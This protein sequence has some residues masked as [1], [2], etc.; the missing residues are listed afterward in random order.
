MDLRGLDDRA[1][2]L[3]AMIRRIK[4]VISV[5]VMFSG[6]GLIEEIHVLASGGRNA[7][8]LVR[9][10]ESALMAQGI[11]IDHKKISIAQL[12]PEEPAAAASERIR[13]LGY[14]VGL[15][16]RTAEVKVRLDWHGASCEGSA[17]GPATANG[18]L[19]VVAEATLRALQQRVPMPATMYLE[20]CTVVKVG[21]HQVVAV[22]IIEVAEN[23][24]LGLVGSCLLGQDDIE[25]VIKATLDALNRRMS[26]LLGTTTS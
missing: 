14:T 9:D 17:Q 26:M 4:D 24:E 19:R 7:K 1:R 12:T 6:D 21:G 23:K 2:E 22:S 15:N 16:G 8:Q 13:I 11:T 25:S 18:R 5:R 10:V 3:E 20:E